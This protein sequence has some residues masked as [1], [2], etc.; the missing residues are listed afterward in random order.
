[1]EK[2]HDDETMRTQNCM[3]YFG[4]GSGWAS[5]I[6]ERFMPTTAT[7]ACIRCPEANKCLAKHRARVKLLMPAA[8]ETWEAIFERYGRLQLSTCR[9]EFQRATGLPSSPYQIIATGNTADG[10]AVAHGAPPADRAHGTIP[11]PFPRAS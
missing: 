8:C 11:Y 10:I 4:F 5:Q 7:G 9:V 1:M 3:G 2:G 6:I